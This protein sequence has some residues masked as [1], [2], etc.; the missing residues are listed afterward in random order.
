MCERRLARAHEGYRGLRRHAVARVIGQAFVSRIGIHQPRF[1]F[2][3]DAVRTVFNAVFR[4]ALPAD[5]PE[6]LRLLAGVGWHFEAVFSSGRTRWMVQELSRTFGISGRAAEAAAREAW[7]LW[8]QARL[9]ELMMPRWVLAAQSSREW[10]RFDGTL[11]ERGLVL[12][13]RAGSRMMAAWAFAERAQAAGLPPDWVGV[14][15]RR[16]LPPEGRGAVRRSWLNQRD[17][18]RRRREDDSLP[19]AWLEDEL[20]LQAHLAARK[21]ALVAVDDQGFTHREPGI[22]FGQPLPMGGLPWELMKEHPTQWMSVERLRDKTHR[23]VLHDAAGQDRATLL[24]RLEADVRRRP[25]HYAMTLVE[26][27][28]RN[29]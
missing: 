10:V 22:L 6:I 27:R 4:E 1:Q 28:M 14:F 16:G 19:V 11:P 8:M 7:D 29:G 17:A 20:A 5:E 26:H 12:H 2:A 24:A 25:G 3:L 23:V 21:L 13:L 15:G 9:E 18:D